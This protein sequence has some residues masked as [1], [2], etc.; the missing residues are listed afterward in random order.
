[1]T[2]I[3]N[4]YFTILKLVCTIKGFTLYQIKQTALKSDY[5]FTTYSKFIDTNWI[6]ELQIWKPLPPIWASCSISTK[7]QA[8]GF[9]A[10]ASHFSKLSPKDLHTW[11][12]CWYFWHFTA[13][14]FVKKRMIE[15]C[16]SRTIPILSIIWISGF[17]CWI[18]WRW[19]GPSRPNYNINNNYAVQ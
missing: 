8:T 17:W 4:H 2:V 15:E 10:L 12:C 16:T 6:K 7:W 18:W 19:R 5:N 14:T 11:L 9:W 1:M 3:R 13:F